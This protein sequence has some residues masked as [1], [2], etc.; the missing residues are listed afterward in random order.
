MGRVTLNGGLRYD[1]L[2]LYIPEQDLDPVQYVGARN[3]DAIYDIPNWH[4]IS[5]RLGATYDL[6]GNG[7][8]ALKWNLGRFIEGQ[9]G[10]FPEQVNPITQNATSTRTWTDANRNYFPDCDLSNQA[11]NGECL[12][13]NNQNFGRPVVPFRYDP[14]AATGWGTRG[15]NWET[16]VGVQHQLLPNLAIDGSYHRRWF[17]NFRASDNLLV[18]P[19]NYDPF[20]VRVPVDA[21][22]PNSGEQLCG[23]YDITP[24]LFGRSD[25]LVTRSSDFGEQSQVYDGFDLTANVRFPGSVT[26]Q[27]GVSTGRTRTNTCF[28]VDS[29]QALLWCDV[30]P[31]MQ[32]Q[33]KGSLVYPLKWWGLQTS[34]AFQSFAG[35]EIL[36]SWAAP[37]SEVVGLG[38]PLSGGA[39]TVTV[40]LISPGTTYGERMTQVDFRVAKNFPLR[41]GRIQP[42]LD[43]YNLF[44]SN[45]VYGQ[46]NTYGTAWLRPTQVLVGRMIKFGVQ[47][48]F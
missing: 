28:T 12:A 48:D 25:T 4:S 9:A 36:A 17:G 44:N 29:P 30:Q 1:Y 13:S 26:A 47:V 32:L 33:I 14:R 45:A 24:T 46:N 40:P 6:F 39:R 11:A 18:T 16:M 38:R 43:L 27:G 2:N 5:P 15:Y 41:G 8:T 35:P 7:R 22:L 42:Q 19:A 21:R 34:V 20:C 23:L 31:P 3:F 37:A 10:G